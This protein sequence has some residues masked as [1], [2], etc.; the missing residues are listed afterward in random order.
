MAK[1]IR[2]SLGIWAITGCVDRFCT[3]GYRQAISTRQQIETAGKIRGLEGLILQHP[4]VITL[5]N[6]QE[7]KK[8]CADAGLDIAAVD[9]N[10]F[11]SEFKNGAISN[12]D[13]ALRRKATDVIKQTMDTAAAVGCENAGLWPGQDGFDYPFQEDMLTAWQRQM[14]CIAEAADHNPEIKICVEYKIGEPR[15]HIFISN[16]GRAMAMCYELG[17]DNVGVTFD[18]GHGFMAKESAAEAAT[19]LALHNKLFSIHFNDAY[20]YFDDDMIAGS[21]HI[22]NTLEM[23]YYV[24]QVGYD[25]WYGFDIFPYREDI[26]AAAELCVEN[27]RDL[28]EVARQIDP[29]KLKEVQSKP[30]AIDSQRYIRDFVIGRMKR[31]G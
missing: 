2:F 5:K 4:N 8:T 17:R 10:I 15:T 11:Q 9:A 3:G 25:G 23:L 29:V 12:A 19:Y 14:D 7:I 31:G 30:G 27:I 13:P 1:D 28:H 22:Y 20:G 18:I 26:V 16:A 21:I 24:H 6:A